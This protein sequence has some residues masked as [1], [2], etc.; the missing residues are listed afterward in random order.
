MTRLRGICSLPKSASSEYKRASPARL[1]RITNSSQPASTR[2]GRP[3]CCSSHSLRHPPRIKYVAVAIQ[4][5]NNFAALF[6]NQ[7][8]LLVDYK[9]A[10]VSDVGDGAQRSST[11]GDA[12]DAFQDLSVSFGVC[13][14][15]ACTYIDCF[16]V[17]PSAVRDDESRWH[18][19]AS[20]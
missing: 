4:K 16:F 1:Q 17:P 11:L 7:K 20:I 15:H 8:L 10:L 9:G 19:G 5:I 6:L 14:Q 12:Y 13:K 2:I 3:R 18:G